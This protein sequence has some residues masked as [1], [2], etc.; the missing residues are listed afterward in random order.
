M[1]CPHG[2]H[3]ILYLVPVPALFNSPPVEGTL[4]VDR[5]LER[6]R[7]HSINSYLGVT[8]TLP[9]WRLKTYILL[10]ATPL[11]QLWHSCFTLETPSPH[12][13][14]KLHPILP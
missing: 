1:H 5:N 12:L 3:H 11:L 2:V 4:S 6:L 9:P 14:S 13:S 8:L 7:M 10:T